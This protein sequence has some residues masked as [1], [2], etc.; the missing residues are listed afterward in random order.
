MMISIRKPWSKPELM[1]LT[2]NHPEEAV[3]APCKTATSGASNTSFVDN[4]SY[5]D[6]GCYVCYSFGGS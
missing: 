6:M 5:W 2:H 1:V 4:C 3:L